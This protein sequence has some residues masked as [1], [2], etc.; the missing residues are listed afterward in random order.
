MRYFTRRRFQHEPYTLGERIGI[1]AIWFVGIFGGWAF[2][3]WAIARAI[4]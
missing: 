3:A 2:I 1:G 4:R